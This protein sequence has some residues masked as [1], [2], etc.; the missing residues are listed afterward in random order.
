M[1]HQPAPLRIVM[2]AEPG[3]SAIQNM[4]FS[5]VPFLASNHM[6]SANFRMAEVFCGKP[7]GTSVDEQSCRLTD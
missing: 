5:V 4:P 3:H 6:L 1:N 7:V 2:C